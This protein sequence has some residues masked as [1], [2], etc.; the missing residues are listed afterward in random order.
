MVNESFIIYHA[1]ELQETITIKLLRK[2]L[3]AIPQVRIQ[4]LQPWYQRTYASE[5]GTASLQNFQGYFCKPAALLAAP[6]KNVLVLDLDVIITD[7]PFVLMD[8]PDYSRQGAYLFVDRR[9]ERP[10][11]LMKRYR[12]QLRDFWK[13]ANSPEE[14]PLVEK[15]PPITGWSYDY[16]ESAVVL[17]NKT[18]NRKAMSILERILAPDLFKGTTKYIN[19]DKELYWQALFFAGVNVSMNPYIPSEI[20]FPNRDD[21][22]TVTCAYKYTFAQWL[23]QPYAT[24]KVFY[25][26]GDGIEKMLTGGDQTILNCTLSDPLV[27]YSSLTQYNT[28]CSRGANPLPQNLINTIWAYKIKYSE[29][30]IDTFED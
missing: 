27:Y 1:D 8:T 20:G 14:S 16:G 17:F 3:E 4:S 23:W 6:F 30:F 18:L 15:L 19:G 26:N 21:K 12:R 10:A 29:S 11:K 28:Y 2:Q 7:N 13:H 9:T 5:F 24:P 22:G 25:V